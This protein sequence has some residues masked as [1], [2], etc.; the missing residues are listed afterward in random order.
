MLV[1]KIHLQDETERRKGKI[2]NK[3]VIITTF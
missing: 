1:G 3:K 2:K